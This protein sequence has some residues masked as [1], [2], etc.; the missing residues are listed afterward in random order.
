MASSS[1]KPDIPENDRR[2][3]YSSGG[4]IYRI[5]AGGVEVAMIAT[6][7][8]QRWGL[9]KG[10]VRRGETAEDAAVREI[11]EETGLNGAV[12]HHLA[13]I[14]YWFRA[15]STRVHKY[16]DF[17]LVRYLS[18]GIVPQQAEVD[19]AR[20]VPLDEAVQLASFEREREILQQVRKLL[21][22]DKTPT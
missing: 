12:D 10:H 16:V 13:T 7:A 17:F 6:N 1:P 15:G 21:A 9:P 5:G 14:D 11:A 8:S 20:W 22:G 19:D 2:I 18:G 3:A 4:V